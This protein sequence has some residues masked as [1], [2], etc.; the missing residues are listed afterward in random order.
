MI[1]SD[2]EITSGL[3]ARVAGDGRRRPHGRMALEEGAGGA[4]GHDWGGGRP[5]G[6]V[7]Q[8]NCEVGQ[9]RSWDRAVVAKCSNIFAEQSRQYIMCNK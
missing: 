1:E 3:G 9:S 6:H 2:E 5:G 4:L 7:R 8:S